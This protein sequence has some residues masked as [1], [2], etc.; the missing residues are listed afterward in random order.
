MI[1]FKTYALGRKA[2]NSDFPHQHLNAFLTFAIGLTIWISVNFNFNFA[3]TTKFAVYRKGRMWAYALVE[4]YIVLGF[5]F[6]WS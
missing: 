4:S 2:K 1:S 3:L 6:V 5:N